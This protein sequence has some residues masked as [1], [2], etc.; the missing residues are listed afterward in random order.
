MKPDFSDIR[1]T[2]IDNTVLSY[3]IQETGANYAIVW[4]KIPSISTTGTQLYLYYGNPGTES[5]SNGET[6][7]LFF[8][9]FDGSTVNTTRW[10]KSGDV[11][12]SNSIATLNT[13]NEKLFS[14]P[15]F[16]SNTAMHARAA[17]N[18]S[19]WGIIGFGDDNNLAAFY[20]N[21][22][23]MGTYNGLN[24]VNGPFYPNFPFLWCS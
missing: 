12:V 16:G 5:L 3:W 7:F 13:V 14:I 4:V 2:T 11:T 1:F 24:R 23:T 8:D 10:A 22:P 20:S 6:T 18:P 21:Y 17:M 15:T 19:I 9:Q